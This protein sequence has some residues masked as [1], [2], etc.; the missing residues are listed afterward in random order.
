MEI[1]EYTF[2]TGVRPFDHNPPAGMA[3]MEGYRDSGNGVYVIPFMCEEVPKEYSLKYCCDNEIPGNEHYLKRE[4]QPGSKIISK[5]AFF[6]K[7]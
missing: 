3:F 5:Y 6:A 2:N 1:K 7:N 4:I